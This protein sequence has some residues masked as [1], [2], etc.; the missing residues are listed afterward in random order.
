MATAALRVRPDTSRSAVRRATALVRSCRRPGAGLGQQHRQLAPQRFERVF[1]CGGFRSDEQPPTLDLQLGDNEAKRFAQAPAQPVAA[2][3]RPERATDGEGD[4]QRNCGGIVEEGAPEG[5]GSDR[6]SG[7][8]QRLERPASADRPDQAESRVR[9]LSRLALM[10]ARP[11]R[12]RMRA[13]KPCLRA[14]RRV[15]GWNVRF[16]GFSTL[17][18]SSCRAVHVGHARRMPRVRVR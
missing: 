6:A 8:C 4:A 18:T 10:I 5:L 1:V 16:T 7:S 13:R 2:D 11:A 9:P 17:S 3:R 14:R 15:F 12:V